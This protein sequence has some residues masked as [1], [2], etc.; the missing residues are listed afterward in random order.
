MLMAPRRV[1]ARHLSPKFIYHALT[2]IHSTFQWLMA[3]PN[4]AYVVPIRNSPVPLNILTAYRV[5]NVTSDKSSS[6]Q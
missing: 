1:A 5:V 2:N 4:A 3:M 6:A